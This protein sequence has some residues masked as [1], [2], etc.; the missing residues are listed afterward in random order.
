MT[1]VIRPQSEV[2]ALM[3]VAEPDTSPSARRRQR[4]RVTVANVKEVRHRLGSLRFLSRG[5]Q[6]RRNFSISGE[7]RGDRPTEGLS[8]LLN[9]SLHLDQEYFFS[10]SLSLR[11]RRA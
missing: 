2:E 11:L 7:H 10:A 8:A 5:N 4:A 1:S 9:R 3:M 6:C